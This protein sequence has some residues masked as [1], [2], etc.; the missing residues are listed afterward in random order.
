MRKRTYAFIIALLTCIVSLECECAEDDSIAGKASNESRSVAL[1]L[2]LQNKHYGSDKIQVMDVYALDSARYVIQASRT[3]EVRK[4][5]DIVVSTPL[6]S[7]EYVKNL[8]I[9]KFAETQDGFDLYMSWGGGKNYYQLIASVSY[10]DHEFL[11]SQVKAT[12]HKLG[13]DEREVYIQRF[14]PKRN[15]KAVDFRREFF[16]ENGDT[17]S[18]SNFERIGVESVNNPSN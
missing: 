14:D 12:H 8:A 4:N 2:A 7:S 6:P 17:F 3:L 9:D 5:G 10:S 11:M 16:G 15:L 1:V 18:F 13:T